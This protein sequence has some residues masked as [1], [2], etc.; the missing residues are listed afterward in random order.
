MIKGMKNRVRLVYYGDNCK[1]AFC[2]PDHLT[3]IVFLVLVINK[4]QYFVEF[5]FVA[6]IAQRYYNCPFSNYIF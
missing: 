3:I 5:I 1:E 6:W 2:S 4:S